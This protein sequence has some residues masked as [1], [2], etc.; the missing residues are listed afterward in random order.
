MAEIRKEINAK[1]PTFLGTTTLTHPTDGNKV[2][3]YPIMAAPTFF[4]LTEA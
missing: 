2:T 4:Y 3:Q 1:D